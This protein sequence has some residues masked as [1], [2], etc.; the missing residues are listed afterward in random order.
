MFFLVLICPR[1]L[2]I[3]LHSGFSIL[4]ILHC[5]FESILLF[6]PV[7]LYVNLKVHNLRAVSLSFIQSLSEDYCPGN[8]QSVALSK[9]LQRGKGEVS[10]YVNFMTGKYK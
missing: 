10:I 9:L 2:L 7:K 4:P 3:A 8:S 5:Y 6:S 1:S